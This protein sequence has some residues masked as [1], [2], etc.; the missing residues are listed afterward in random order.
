MPIT[1]TDT[2]VNPLIV[3]EG[4]PVAA[5]EG[6]TVADTNPLDS[7]ETVSITLS[8]TLSQALGRNYSFYPTA[9]DLGSISDPNGGGTW[10]PA[11]ET[12]TESGLVSGDPTFATKLLSRL[13]YSTPQLANGQAFAAQASITVSNGSDARTDSPLVVVGDVAPPAITGTVA[14]QPVASGDKIPPFATA[15]VTEPYFGYD[16]YTII[17]G[18][19]N[20]T[21]D[22][23]VNY[24]YNA[25]DS[26]TITITDGGKA[27]DADGYLS[28]PGL[29]ETPGVAGTYTLGS[30]YAYNIQNELRGLSFQIVA[31][32]AGAAE[33]PQFELDVTDTTSGLTT[34]DTKTSLLIRGPTPKPPPYIAGIQAAQTVDPGNTIDPFSSVT[35]SDG[36]ANPTDSAMITLTGSGTLTGATAAGNGVYTLAATDPMT[37]TSELDSLAFH[38]AG[39]GTADFE[40]AVSDP[41]VPS[42]T[43][44]STSVTV[45]PEVNFQI[46][47]QTTE[48]TSTSAGMPYTGPTAGLT[49]EFV[50]LSPDKLNIAALTPNVFIYSGT[51]EDGINVSQTGGNNTLDAT[52]GSNFL[53]GGSGND[54]FFLNDLNPTGP[55]W[56]TL[57]NFHA[58]DAATV[59]GVTPAD[60][61]VSWATDEEGHNGLTM[62][63][64]AAGKPAELL[65]LASMGMADLSNGH[66]AVQY[67]TANG[68]PYLEISHL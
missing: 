1:I 33:N 67:G 56:S 38:P 43:D 52:G 62:Q 45:T 61:S 46:L 44:A 20:N 17:A 12:F 18:N 25:K 31:L 48:Q 26:V 19:P 41:A 15:T 22:Y 30:N 66:L 32:A 7:T 23:G 68:T 53:A 64:T 65:T 47:D 4:Q 40:L 49:T 42:A 50:D 3:A 57:L 28:G 59:W 13:V 55:I 36:N 35:V 8:Q 21:Y 6:A 14:D 5:Y 9:A 58:G 24:Y 11:T 51:G 34:S 39:A 10:N 16:Y 63:V 27:T 60:F 2:V 54:T 37:L 29:S